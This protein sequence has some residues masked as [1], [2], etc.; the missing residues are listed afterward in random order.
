[1][2]CYHRTPS[3]LYSY[4]RKDLPGG[5]SSKSGDNAKKISKKVLKKYF[6]LDEV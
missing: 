4:P 5:I 3:P 2:F 6:F 1:M